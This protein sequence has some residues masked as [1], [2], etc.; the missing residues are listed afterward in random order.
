MSSSHGRRCTRPAHTRPPTN[1]A[2]YSG[3][4]PVAESIQGKVFFIPDFKHYRP[5]II[6][7][8]AAAYRKVAENYRDLLPGDT[9][10][11]DLQGKWALT[12]R[13]G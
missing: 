10:P 5:E 13:K 4:L 6:A 8:Y 1:R 11:D 9:Q 3:S 7:E 2:G 12:A